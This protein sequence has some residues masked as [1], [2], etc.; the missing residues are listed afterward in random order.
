MARHKDIQFAGRGRSHVARQAQFHHLR[1]VVREFA[2]RL[3]AELRGDPVVQDLA[4]YGCS[5]LMHLVRLLSPRMD[6]EDHTKDIDF[7]RSRIESRWKAGH[8]HVRKVLARK[9]WENRVD[10]L[11]G[12]IIHEASE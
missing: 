9:P 1:H 11:A 10:T 4:E 2:K 8:D 7:T 3:P 12:I 5:R 6:G